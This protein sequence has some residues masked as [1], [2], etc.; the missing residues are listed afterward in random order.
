M[1]QCE[2][3]EERAGRE[4]HQQ[5][6]ASHGANSRGNPV[7]LRGSMSRDTLGQ[8]NCAARLSRLYLPS[9]YLYFSPML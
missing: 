6:H 1:S 4:A 2:P 8:M 5:R 3:G 9:H 7:T